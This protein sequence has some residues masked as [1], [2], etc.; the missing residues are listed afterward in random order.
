MRL[1]IANK[2]YSSWS[3]RPWVLLQ[4]L[5]V[6]F[7]ERLIPFFTPE[8]ESY[9]A[10]SPN[11]MVPLLECS[12]PGEGGANTEEETL[13]VWDSFAIV[14]YIAENHPAWPDGV[15]ARAWARSAAAEMHSGF[16]EIRRVCTMNCGIRVRLFEWSPKLLSEFERL[17]ALWREGLDRFGGPFLAGSRFG[18]V[19]AFYAPVAFRV[20]TYRPDLSSEALEYVDHLLERPAMQAWYRDALAEPWR[21]PSHED[22]VHAV[23][24]IVE[25]LRG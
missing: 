8:W 2:N 17:D 12:V 25:D 23:G 13:R 11:A 20:Q 3:L 24:E 4:E 21:D 5:G 18:A 1:T 15:T 7:E 9:V 16:L 14:E 10:T 6:H 19:D 22:E